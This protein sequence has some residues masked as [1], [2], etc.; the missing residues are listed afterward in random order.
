MLSMLNVT[1]CS[2][3]QLG[4]NILKSDIWYSHVII[5]MSDSLVL[6]QFYWKESL[7]LL[8]QTGNPTYQR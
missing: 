7:S 4:N 6:L 2:Y 1:K 3:V 5:G 8:L